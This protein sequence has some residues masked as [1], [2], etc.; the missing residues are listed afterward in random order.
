MCLFR[1]Q[2]SGSSFTPGTK[3][4]QDTDTALVE[5]RQVTKEDEVADIGYGTEGKKN[6]EG[7]DDVSNPASSLAINTPKDTTAS[8]SGVNTV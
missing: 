1:T 2:R 6:L 8:T 5:G 7:I 4:I 3:P